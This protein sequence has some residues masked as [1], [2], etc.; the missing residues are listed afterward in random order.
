[1][2][3]LYLQGSGWQILWRAL[4]L[5]EAFAALTSPLLFQGGKLF[6]GHW[7]YKVPFAALMFPP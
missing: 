4:L 5:Q 3:L 2:L 6:E 1:M 7:F